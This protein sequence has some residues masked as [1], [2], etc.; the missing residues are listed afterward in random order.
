MEYQVPTIQSFKPNETN[1]FCADGSSASAASW[2]QTQCD[3]GGAPDAAG[4][5]DKC[6]TGLGDSNHIFQSCSTGTSN[7]VSACETGNS[8]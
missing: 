2:A 1:G 3:G 5:V 8:P 6:S 7:A 4:S